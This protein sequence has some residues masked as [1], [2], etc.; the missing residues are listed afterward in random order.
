MTFD[1]QLWLFTRGF[2]TLPKSPMSSESGRE[3]SELTEELWA[4][5][6]ERGVEA[7]ALSYQQAADVMRSLTSEKV[8]GLFVITDDAAR[9][10]APTANTQTRQLNS[11]GTRKV[12][13]KN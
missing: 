5:L 3:M 7:S 11:N 1:R 12:R 2:A 8:S 10:V 13:R 4:V 6:S 9:R